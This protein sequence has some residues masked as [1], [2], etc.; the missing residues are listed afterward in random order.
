MLHTQIPIGKGFY[1]EHLQTLLLPSLSG[2][3]LNAIGK[4]FYIEHSFFL[5]CQV[6]GSML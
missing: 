2:R 4:G 6:V 3:W 5:H 1:I